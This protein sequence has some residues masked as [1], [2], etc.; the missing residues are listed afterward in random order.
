MDDNDWAKYAKCRDCRHY[1]ATPYPEYN[2]KLA[3]CRSE[4]SYFYKVGLN[5]L[6]SKDC[7]ERKE[8]PK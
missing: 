7:F 8:Q 2:G 4:R 1:D 5:T 3:R 6:A